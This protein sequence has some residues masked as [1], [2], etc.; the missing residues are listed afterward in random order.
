MVDW[1]GGTGG[2][3]TVVDPDT[4]VITPDNKIKK[5]GG[6]WLN[7]STFLGGVLWNL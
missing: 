5:D 7:G 6:V 3:G 1:T 4:P 2:G